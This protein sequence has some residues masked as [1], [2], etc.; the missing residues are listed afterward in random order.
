MWT[1]CATSP[2]PMRPM[3]RIF[4]D[5]VD[6]AVSLDVNWSMVWVAGMYL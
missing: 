6:G 3:L 2:Q 5:E 1:I 4:L